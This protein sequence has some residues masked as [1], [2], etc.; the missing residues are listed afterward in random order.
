VRRL[1]GDLH[2][3]TRGILGALAARTH[4]LELAEQLYR[5]C[6]ERPEG[7]GT[8]EAEVYATSRWRSTS[9]PWLRWKR[10]SLTRGRTSS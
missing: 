4:Q 8:M 6:L 5:A 1:G 3:A 9:K 7:P 10:Q 2:F